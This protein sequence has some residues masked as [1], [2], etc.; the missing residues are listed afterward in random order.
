MPRRESAGAGS[1]R[2]SDG[3]GRDGYKGRRRLFGIKKKRSF[4]SREVI[5]M[6][7]VLTD[8]PRAERVECPAGDASRLDDDRRT[9]ILVDPVLDAPAVPS[10]PATRRRFRRLASLRARRWLHR[11]CAAAVVLAVLVLVTPAHSG[12]PAS[13]GTFSGPTAHPAVTSSVPVASAKSQ[14][15]PSFACQSLTPWLLR[16]GCL[17]ASG[18]MSGSGR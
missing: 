10:P 5:T 2:S 1:Q 15:E 16:P 3:P 8:G 17:L 9:P 14:P 13:T 6:S 18:G 7:V 12:S 4:A 11:A